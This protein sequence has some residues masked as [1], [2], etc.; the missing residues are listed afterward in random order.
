MSAVAG[1]CVTV[2]VYVMLYNLS[3]S[4]IIFKIT[5]LSAQYC[6]IKMYLCNAQVIKHKQ[7]LHDLKR[8]KRRSQTWDKLESVLSLSS[9]IILEV[10]WGCVEVVQLKIRGRGSWRDFSNA[11]QIS[12]RPIDDPDWLTG[13]VLVVRHYWFCISYTCNQYTYTYSGMGV[14]RMFGQGSLPQKVRSVVGWYMIVIS[15]FN[16]FPE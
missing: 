13:V 15:P 12:P 14:Y 1:M 16:H 3:H 4:F 10:F 5:R 9:T 11:S 2:L 8:T 6:K 7:P